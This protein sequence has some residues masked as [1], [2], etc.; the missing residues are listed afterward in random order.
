MNKQTKVVL[1]TYAVAFG[2]FTA[3]NIYESHLL[4]KETK[5]FNEARAES[6][7]YLSGLQS[8]SEFVEN[9]LMQAKFWEQ[10]LIEE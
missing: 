4:N 9:K 7:A 6:N 2:C 10:V 3:L 5:K 8:K 1:T